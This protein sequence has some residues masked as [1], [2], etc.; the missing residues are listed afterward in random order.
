MYADANPHRDTRQ[1][2]Q[3]KGAHE[4]QDVQCHVADVH[5][6]P[7]SVSPRQTRSDHVGVAYRLHLKTG[8]NASSVCDLSHQSLQIPVECFTL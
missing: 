5:R 1:M 3:L 8:E 7:V 6:V 2:S 4:L